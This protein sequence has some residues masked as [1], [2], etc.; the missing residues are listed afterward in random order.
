MSA[1]SAPSDNIHLADIDREPARSAPRTVLVTR[2]SA[3]VVLQLLVGM[4]IGTLTCPP[5]P[6]M[7]WLKAV[8]NSTA[9]ANAPTIP[10]HETGAKL[11][12]N[13]NC[14]YYIEDT[15]LGARSPT[16]QLQLLP[17][18]HQDTPNSELPFLSASQLAL[19]SDRH[20]NT[21]ISPLYIVVDDIVYD[22]TQ[23]VHDH[24][25]GPRVIQSFRGQDCSWQFWRFHS[26]ENMKEWGH[27]LRVARTQGVKNRWKERPRFVGLRKFGAEEEG[28]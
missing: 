15:N 11:D 26:K 1:I 19:L 8:R 22:C 6:D 24:P 27:P 16:Q 4:N 10:S 2:S 20:G 12:V 21:S 28:W 25:G 3:Y 14:V 5:P 18:A 7:G 17:L 23:F 13:Q 9:E